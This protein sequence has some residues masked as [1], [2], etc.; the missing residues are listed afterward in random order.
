MHVKKLRYFIHNSIFSVLEANIRILLCV[1]WW[2]YSCCGYHHTEFPYSC[3][4]ILNQAV[5]LK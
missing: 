4:F 5:E 3:V 2:N 1:L